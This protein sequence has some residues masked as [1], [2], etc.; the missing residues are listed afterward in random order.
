MVKITFAKSQ[1]KRI[2]LTQNYAFVLHLSLE[3]LFLY[4]IE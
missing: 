2:H 1:E 3:A 4:F